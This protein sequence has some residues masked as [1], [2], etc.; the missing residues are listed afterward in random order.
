MFKFFRSNIF[1]ILLGVTLILSG[2]LFYTFAF[3]ENGLFDVMSYITLPFEKIS[4]EISNHAISF[5]GE[6]KKSY[7]LE[8]EIETLENEIRSLRN[9]VVD[10][11]DTKK[12]NAQYAKYYDLK[13]ENNS[14]KFVSA[15]VVGKDPGEFF[16]GFTIDR[17]SLAGISEND[18]V[19]TEN[20]IVGY[21]FYVNANSSKVK[22]VLSPDV[23]IGVVDKISLDCGVISGNIELADQNLTRMTLIPSHNNIN[24]GDFVVSSGLSGMYPKNLLLGKIISLEYDSDN[25][26][27]YAIVEPFEKIKDVQDVFVVVEFQGKGK[28]VENTIKEDIH[29]GT[30]EDVKYS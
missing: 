19:I 4:A 5:L 30:Q 14:L 23:K 27:N 1:R 11:Y 21:V 13:K 15:S 24:P 29:S 17:G 10:Y 20:G 8:L 7:E 18:A 12:E 3:S 2:I 26:S 6:R 9:M 16:Q 25:A 22:T 28:I